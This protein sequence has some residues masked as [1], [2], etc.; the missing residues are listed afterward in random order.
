M[1]KFLFFKKKKKSM[2]NDNLTSDGEILDNME[3]T[4]DLK[5]AEKAEN[6]EEYDNLSNIQETETEKLKAE[7][8]EAKDKYLRLF[9]EFD[10]SRRRNAKERLDLI[11]TAGQEILQDLLPVLD[12]LGRAEKIMETATDIENVKKGFDL[13]KEKLEKTLATKG[14]KAM[15]SIGTDFD[16][17]LHEAITE[18][19]APSSE[20]VGKV[21]DEVEKGYLLNDKIIRYAKVIVGK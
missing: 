9:A 20:M 5:D 14:L 18:I 17:D 12:D 7:L 13:I 2:T 21:I 8:G 10:N 19:P 1:A 16:A 15:E 4:D 3:N 6:V 11:K